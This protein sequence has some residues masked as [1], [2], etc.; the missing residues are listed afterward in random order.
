MTFKDI[1]RTVDVSKWACI[2]YLKGIKVDQSYSTLL[3]KEAENE[4]SSVLAKKGFTNIFNL[5]AICPS[6]TWDYL[7]EKGKDRWL[8][9]VTINQ[10]KSVS[11]KIFRIVEGY[12]HAI[13]YKQDDKWTLVELNM[14]E[15]EG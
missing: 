10:G 7:A 8:I 6:P 1:A 2:K 11:D 14:T 5:N 4:A 3:W 9:D 13:L 15:I 12:R